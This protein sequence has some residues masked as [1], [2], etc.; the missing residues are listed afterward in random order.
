MGTHP[1]FESDF[2]CLTEKNGKICKWKIEN[3]KIMES[4]E[5]KNPPFSAANETYNEYSLDG[6]I[7]PFLLV[8]GG[9]I[10]LFIGLCVCLS[11][12]CPSFIRDLRL[13]TKSNG[14]EDSDDE[15]GTMTTDLYSSEAYVH[16]TELKFIS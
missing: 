11:C 12:V 3:E 7:L 10:I 5:Y 14:S 13:E 16:G 8:F 1:I 15:S 6:S 2:D 4:S 9:V